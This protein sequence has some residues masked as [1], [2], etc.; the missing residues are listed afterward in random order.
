MFLNSK[1]NT[2]Y[3]NIKK[4]ILNEGA[5]DL[6]KENQKIKLAIESALIKLSP[7]ELDDDENSAIEVS[8]SGKIN[9][10]EETIL[11]IISSIQNKLVDILINEKDNYSIISYS[12]KLKT[13]DKILIVPNK[14]LK[15]TLFET[16]SIELLSNGE[17]N[18]S[19]LIEKLNIVL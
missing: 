10:L 8:L 11:K 19:N 2:N 4:N 14:K 1:L 3:I 12:I 5:N 15:T 13:L 6:K 16:I 7:E 18:A 9:E 17:N